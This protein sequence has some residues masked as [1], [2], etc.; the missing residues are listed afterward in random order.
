MIWTLVHEQGAIVDSIANHV[1]LSADFVEN[2]KQELKKASNF[3]HKYRKK[4]LILAILLALILV[5]LIIIIV[6]EVQ[7]KKKITTVY[8]K[9]PSHYHTH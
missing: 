7:K 5:I 9:P 3:Q 8:V 6:V 1:D 2:S 4:K